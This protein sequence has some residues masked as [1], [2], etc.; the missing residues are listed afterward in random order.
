MTGTVSVLNVA[1][2]DI[3][4]RFDKSNLAERIRAGRVVRDML[5]R[6]YAL[7]V[8][9]ERDG[10]KAFERALDFDET[11]GV[12]LIAD[13]DP[14]AAR[15]TGPTLK[16][17]TQDG[18]SEGGADQAAEVGAAAEPQP[19]KRRGRPRKE[20]PA[21]STRAVAVSRSAGG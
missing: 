9:V 19:G 12:Y 13:Y 18:A 8:E 2:G 5:R 21:E 1:G 4:L 17:E 16:K 6:G 11:K 7:L 14:E 3:E 20:L 10:E 15:Q